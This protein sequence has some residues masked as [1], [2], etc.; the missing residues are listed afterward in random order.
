[1]AGQ[2]STIGMQVG[3]PEGTADTITDTALGRTK[4]SVAGSVCH[5]DE[6]FE[7]WVAPDSGGCELMALGPRNTCS[8]VQVKARLFD[9]GLRLKQKKRE[10]KQK[11]K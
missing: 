6:A 2:Y 10:Q 5:L 4:A 8:P 11:Q 3:L 9:Q 1:M 7:C